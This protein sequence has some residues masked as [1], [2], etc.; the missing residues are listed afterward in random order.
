MLAHILV[1]PTDYRLVRIVNRA[2]HQEAVVLGSDVLSLDYPYLRHDAYVA[3]KWAWDSPLS[4]SENRSAIF[5][6][7]DLGRFKGNKGPKTGLFPCSFLGMW[8]RRC[9]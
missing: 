1:L 4:F 6:S 9:S 2:H 7:A 3:I 5:Y 8:L